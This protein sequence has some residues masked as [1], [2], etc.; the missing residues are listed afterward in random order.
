M[1]DVFDALRSVSWTAYDGGGGGRFYVLGLAPNAGRPR[2]K[3][4][5]RGDRVGSPLEIAR[6]LRRHRGH[7]CPAS[8]GIQATQLYGVTRQGGDVPGGAAEAILAGRAVSDHLARSRNPCAPGPNR[9]L[10]PSG[11]QSSR[12]S[13]TDTGARPANEKEELDRGPRSGQPQPRL[14][15]GSILRSP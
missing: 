3:K 11:P 13:S 14:S 7:A 12:P 2:R 10:R 4:L 9:K 8:P 6:A 5:D 1:A 15:V